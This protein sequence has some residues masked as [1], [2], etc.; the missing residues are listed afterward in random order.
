MKLRLWF[1]LYCLTAFIL[2]GSGRALG[3]DGPDQGQKPVENRP[4]WVCVSPGARPAYVGIQGG[5]APLTLNACA[6]GSIIAF[7]GT[8]GNDF[9]KILHKNPPPPAVVHPVTAEEPETTLAQAT[10]HAL[11]VQTLLPVGLDKQED[12]ILA[13]VPAREQRVEKHPFKPLRLGSYKKVLRNT[14]SV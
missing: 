7:T 13:E 12:V 10:P 5:T 3:A 11:S 6:D 9:T 14:G 4:A 8:S 1:L 2:P